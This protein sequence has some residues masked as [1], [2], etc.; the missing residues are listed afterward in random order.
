MSPT[1]I[2]PFAADATGSLGE[3]G[4]N[5]T[6]CPL[7]EDIYFCPICTLRVP[8]NIRNSYFRLI[9][10]LISC[11][12]LPKLHVNNTHS[13]WNR[14]VCQRALWLKKA[15]YVGRRTIL[16]ALLSIKFTAPL[17][18]LPSEWMATSVKS[19]MG[20]EGIKHTQISDN[21]WPS[22]SYLEVS[23]NGFLVGNTVK[24]PLFG[25][26]LSRQK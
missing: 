15:T 24:G 22:I 23:H 9:R 25:P 1:N 14:H 17:C 12:Y 6:F 3:H 20:L 10:L 13:K 26:L 7:L 16:I 19:D 8:H 4:R 5:L 21:V 11:P 18:D 2:R